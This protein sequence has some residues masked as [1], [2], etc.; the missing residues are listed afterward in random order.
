MT[1]QEA[2]AYPKQAVVDQYKKTAKE[3]AFDMDA[4]MTEPA[5]APRELKP[6]TKKVMFVSAGF[7]AKE[8]QQSHVIADQVKN[9]VPETTEVVAFENK[10]F[11]VTH[12]AEGDVSDKV[13]WAADV[14]NQIVSA[15]DRGY[16]PGAVRQAQEAYAYH[17]QNPGV[18]IQLLGHSAGGLQ[19]RETQAIL[20]ELGV[21][22]KVMTLASPVGIAGEANTPNAVN[23]MGEKD[24]IQNF[25]KGSPYNIPGVEGHAFD[26]YAANESVVELIRMFSESGVTPELVSKLE[27]T[28]TQVQ[29]NGINLEKSVVELLDNMTAVVMNAAG[30][31]SPQQ[32]K[33]VIQAKIKELSS[34]IKQ[35]AEGGD[36]S[37]QAG[38]ARKGFRSTEVVG[39]PVHSLTGKPL[40]R[41]ETQLSEQEAEQITFFV[42]G[43]G[44]THGLESEHMGTELAKMLP[45]HMVI[46][47]ETPENE[48]VP[49][50]GETATSPSFLKKAINAISKDMNYEGDSVAAERIAE[51]A[52]M[53]HLQN[54]TTH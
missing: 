41:A 45:D 14:V 30:L 4:R 39:N 17:L 24:G 6:G 54:P 38:P 35:R 13:G 46:A 31:M 11:E 12:D 18:E 8:G 10:E 40:P 43:F 20:K 15:L 3:S 7:S 42:G 53:Y 26:L 50:E 28:Q 33:A 32:S 22:S 5:N 34:K 36:T 19:A 44:G 52:Y 29:Q 2:A 9:I 23:L 37:Y 25:D 27:E 48:I 47:V 51:R 1:V 49:G 16:N 21:D